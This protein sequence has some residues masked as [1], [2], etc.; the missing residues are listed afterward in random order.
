MRAGGV[1]RQELL[2][3]AVRPVIDIVVCA[4]LLECDRRELL[5]LARVV[6]KGCGTR[7]AELGKLRVRL[8][9]KG[10]HLWRDLPPPK[11]QKS[12]FPPFF[13]LLNDVIVVDVVDV[14]LVNKI[15]LLIQI[16]LD[17]YLLSLAHNKNVLSVASSTYIRRLLPAYP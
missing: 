14:L 5:E 10:R 3:L 6:L 8:G 4:E 17:V 13:T 16:I 2:C 1:Q 15:V 9:G 12:I 11:N 7:R